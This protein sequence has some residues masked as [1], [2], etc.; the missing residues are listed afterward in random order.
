[1]RKEIPEPNGKTTL[2]IADEMRDKAARIADEFENKTGKRTSLA[3]IVHHLIGTCSVD[4]VA[5]ELAN[6]AR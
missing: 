5:K 2:I 6:D 1:M 4:K 3:M